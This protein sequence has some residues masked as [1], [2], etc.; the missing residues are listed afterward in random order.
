MG[1]GSEVHMPRFYLLFVLSAFFV[2]YNPS[3]GAAFGDEDRTV[4][5]SIFGWIKPP[6]WIYARPE[7][8][9]FTPLVSNRDPQNEH[10]AAFNGQ[11]WDPAAWGSAWTP[12]KAVEKFFES[13]IFER[14]YVTKGGVPVVELGP[15][16]YSLSG[17]DQSRTLKLMTDR[18]GIFRKGV[19]AV[20][21]T[22]W[23]T[24]D[25]VGVYTPQ[26]LFLN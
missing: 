3:P 8:Y 25:I 14:R 22:D 12:D 4:N 10:P 19:S 1:M 18:A 20:E 2:L 13:R 15:T 11:D 7:H 16:F 26:G 17:Q 9:E 21:L 6:C 23:S 24:H 5:R